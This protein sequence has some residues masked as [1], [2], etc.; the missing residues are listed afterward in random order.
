MD[1]FEKQAEKLGHKLHEPKS[2]NTEDGS[3]DFIKKLA[4]N[5]SP[6][7]PRLG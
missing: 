6:S 1:L 7:L 5:D 4:W 3:V 2:N